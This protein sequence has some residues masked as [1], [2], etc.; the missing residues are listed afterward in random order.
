MIGVRRS[1]NLGVSA[2]TRKIAIRHQRERGPVSQ[3]PK[4][5]RAAVS[6][7]RID[8]RKVAFAVL[9]LLSFVGFGSWSLLVGEGRPGDRLVGG[10]LMFLCLAMAVFLAR[11]LRRAGPVVEVGP[12]GLLDRRKPDGLIPWSRIAG[13][14]IKRASI[15]RGIRVTLDDGRRLDID[16]QLLDVDRKELMRVIAETARAAE[17]RGEA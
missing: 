4:R 11:D 7:Y 9:L 8:K 12:E 10:V 1:Y 2:A 15:V 16:T 3:I 17:A 5:R 6:T 13:A 14:E